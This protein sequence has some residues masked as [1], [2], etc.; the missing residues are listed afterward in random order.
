MAKY[1]NKVAVFANLA[2]LLSIVLMVSKAE[3]K[4]LGSKLINFIPSTNFRILY[5]H[6][7]IVNNHITLF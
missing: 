6:A 5:M 7:C 4:V 2:L 1:N 3:S